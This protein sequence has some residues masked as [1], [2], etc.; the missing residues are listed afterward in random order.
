MIFYPV[1][2]PPKNYTD[3]PDNYI[4]REIVYLSIY[5]IHQRKQRDHYLIY[6]VTTG[7][8]KGKN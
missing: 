1:F 8:I 7:N 3:K 6:L 2:V 5:F 4:I